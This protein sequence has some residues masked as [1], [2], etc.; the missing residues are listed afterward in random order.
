MVKVKMYED[1]RL[2]LVGGICEGQVVTTVQLSRVSGGQQYV[3]LVVPEVRQSEQTQ[4]AEVSGLWDTQSI[5]TM[6]T[7]VDDK[8]CPNQ[9]RHGLCLP[10]KGRR[11]S[12]SKKGKKVAKDDDKKVM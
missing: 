10:K 12:F 3:G 1:S 6:S 2:P 4:R 9:G 8:G 11:S 7:R 5:W